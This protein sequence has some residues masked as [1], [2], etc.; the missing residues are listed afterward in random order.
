L[1]QRFDTE[2]YLESIGRLQEILRGISETV[3]EV[4]KWR[5]PYKNV[6]DRCTASFGCRNQ[7]HKVPV[8]KLS[9]C[10]GDDNLDYRNA[11]EQS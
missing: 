3:T 6:E 10:T 2:H 5:C 1:R 4:S 7:D 8:G 11:W 9:L